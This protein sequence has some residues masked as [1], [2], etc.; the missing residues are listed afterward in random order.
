MN[1]IFAC[2]I[3]DDKPRQVTNPLRQAVVGKISV[4]VIAF[5]YLGYNKCRR[6]SSD[7]PHKA[8]GRRTKTNRDDVRSTLAVI[9]LDHRPG[10]S[11]Q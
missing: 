5:V 10:S 3:R 6:E 1:F 9:V 8:N 4:R 11:V 2:V 7:V